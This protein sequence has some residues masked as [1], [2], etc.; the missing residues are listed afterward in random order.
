MYLS[1]TTV[2]NRIR[3]RKL[4]YSA[5]DAVLPFM[6]RSRSRTC[7]YTIAGMLMWADY[8][9]YE[10][11][12]IDNTLFVKGVAEN[13]RSI[14][15]FSLPIGDMPLADAVA[16]LRGYCRDQGVPLVF[17]AV[18]EDRVAELRALGECRVEE[19]ADWADYL[20][21]ARDL[22]TLPGNRYSKKRNHVNRF[23]S[24]HPG[25]TLIELTPDMV[26][27]VRAFLDTLPLDYEH[28]TAL[29]ER[30][31][32]DRMLDMWG[33]IPMDGAVL[34]TPDLGIVAF[35]IGE[36][37][38]DTLYVHIEKMAHGVNGAG[39]SINKGFAS[40]MLERY[41]MAYVNREEDAGDEG[42]RKAK[43]SYHP[44][45]MLRKYNVE[46]L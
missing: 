2:D 42:L 12:V 32:V 23:V 14:P 15:A 29:V 1:T 5:L 13:D 19:L 6:R 44:V 37:V 3:F 24:D 39:E 10:Y 17:S 41:G 33:M 46:L 8:F 30:R 9:G 27:D 7:D 38:G 11:A 22:A 4:D 16:L 20:Y 34:R 45:M 18:P 26:D 40:M 25:S 21:N 36:V 28:E 35:A 43:E 31:E